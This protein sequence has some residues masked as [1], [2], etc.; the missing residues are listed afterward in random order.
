MT[1]AHLPQPLRSRALRPCRPAVQEAAHPAQWLV[2]DAQALFRIYEQFLAEGFEGG[3]LRC[4][5]GRYKGGRVAEASQIAIKIKP[6]G[7]LP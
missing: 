4:P 5:E 3:V 2:E 1:L 6:G 7:I